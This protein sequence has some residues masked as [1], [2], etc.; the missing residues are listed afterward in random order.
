M[1]ITPRLIVSSVPA[2]IDF[3]TKV[4]E[5]REQARHTLSHGQVVDAVITIGDSTL[6]LADEAQRWGMLAPTSLGGSPL[7]LTLEHAD[8]DAL[9]ARA[10]ANGAH[11]VIAL[12]NQFY[13]RR[14]GRIRDPFGHLWILS[15]TLETLSETELARRLAEYERT[16]PTRD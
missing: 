14:Q 3:Y 4:F 11:V 7:M 16:L 15:K 12:A 2:A 13:G 8:P 6:S 1:H 5:A 9:C 10:V